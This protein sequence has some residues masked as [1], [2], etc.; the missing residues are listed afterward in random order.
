LEIFRDLAPGGDYQV[1]NNIAAD[2]VVELV[3][4][5]MP[6]ASIAVADLLP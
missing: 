5:G 2:G 6:V 3:I 4:D 1:T